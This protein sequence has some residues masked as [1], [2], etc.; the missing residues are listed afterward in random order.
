MSAPTTIKNE[1]TRLFIGDTTPANATLA[2]AIS[3]ATVGF[4]CIITSMDGLDET[5]GTTSDDAVYCT[6]VENFTPDDSDDL[7]VSNFVLSGYVAKDSADYDEAETLGRAMVRSGDQGTFV[8][9]EP[10]TVDHI[11][12]EMKVV[13]F[14]KKRGGPKDKQRFEIELIART[15]PVYEAQP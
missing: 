1:K 14:A 8:L 5:R 3:A 2:E 9:I 13:K 12:M 4:G 11:W 7:K 15:L 10:N 6:D